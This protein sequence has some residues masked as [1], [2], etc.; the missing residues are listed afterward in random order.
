MLMGQSSNQHGNRILN[1]V[2]FSLRV[3]GRVPGGSAYVRK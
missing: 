2:K 3:Q 1:D